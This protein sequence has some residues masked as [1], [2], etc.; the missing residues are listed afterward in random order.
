MEDF[1]TGQNRALPWTA[2]T[3]TVAALVLV[4]WWSAAQRPEADPGHQVVV[5]DAAQAASS[6]APT[7]SGLQLA[8]TLGLAANASVVRPANLPLQNVAR[9]GVQPVSFL[10]MAK[11]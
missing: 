6:K 9:D 3:L 4:T 7:G 8:S 10:P 1:S 2:N 11:H 5:V